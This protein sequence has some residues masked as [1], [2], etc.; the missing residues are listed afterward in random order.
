MPG[1]RLVEQ[2]SLEHE[3]DLVAGAI[4][5][6]QRAR[7][8]R[9]K[10]AGRFRHAGDPCRVFLDLALFHPI[11]G[12]AL[13]AAHRGP[14]FL[15]LLNQQGAHAI[16]GGKLGGHGAARTRTDNEDVRSIVFMAGP[17]E[18]HSPEV[19]IEATAARPLSRIAPTG[20]TMAHSPHS[21]QVGRNS[22]VDVSCRKMLFVGHAP[23]QAPQCR[24]I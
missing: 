4:D 3:A 12:D 22:I 15:P 10:N 18:S 21:V 14:D 24:Q 2:G 6:Y 7:P 16:A 1:Q 11:S 19:R 8:V 17:P 20:Q 23:T 5:V 13:G 9:G